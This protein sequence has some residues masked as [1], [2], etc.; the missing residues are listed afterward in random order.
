MRMLAAF[1]LEVSWFALFPAAAKSCLEEIPI[2]L[3]GVWDLGKVLS[4]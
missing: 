1:Q 2:K 3:H 4:F